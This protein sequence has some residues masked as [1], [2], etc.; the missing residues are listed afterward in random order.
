M[1]SRSTLLFAT[2]CLIAA[3]APGLEAP[4]PVEAFQL[5]PIVVTGRPGWLEEE[6]LVGEYQRPEWT[7]RRRFSTTRTYIQYEPWEVATEQWWRVR[8]YNDRNPKHLFMHEIAMGLPYRMQADVYFDWAHEGGRNMNKDI[9]FELR[10]ALADWDVI[11]LNPTLY[12]EYKATD[13]QYGSDVYETKLLLGDDLSPR[14]HWAFNAA[15]ERE[16]A[17]GRANEFALTQGLSYTLIDQVLSTGLEMQYKYENEQSG[18]QNG[19][20]K[21]QI[22]PSFQINPNRNSWINLVALFGC[23]RESPAVEGFIV[24]GYNFGRAG[25]GRSVSRPIAA[26]R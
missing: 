3:S 12:F 10:W 21:F 17:R 26:P 20:R 13:G 4:D 7:T 15:Y 9:A 1:N 24:V 6:A 5:S 18:R 25:R 22:G 14:L 11:P 8:N 16:V 19:G 23:T 2:C